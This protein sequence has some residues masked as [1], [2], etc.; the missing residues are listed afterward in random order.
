MAASVNYGSQFSGAFTFVHTNISP[1]LITIQLTYEKIIVS[2]DYIQNP[3]FP[4]TIIEWNNIDSNI[5]NSESPMLLYFYTFIRPSA[6]N[7]FHSLKLI[8]RLRLGSSHLRFH[9]FK[10]SSQ[11]VLNPI[12]NC[13]WN[14]GLVLSEFSGNLGNV[15]K[16]KKDFHLPPVHWLK[17]SD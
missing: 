1:G 10:H 7:T 4:L 16:R 5:R 17:K 3:F 8:T 14:S 15:E 2:V 11:D 9:K 12:C 6:N 13:D